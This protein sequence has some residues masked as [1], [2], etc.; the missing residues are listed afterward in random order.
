MD[1]EAT[2]RIVLLAKIDAFYKDRKDFIGED[3]QIIK[4]LR[5]HCGNWVSCN[6]RWLDTG[7]TC[8]FYK[9]LLKKLDQQPT[10]EDKTYV[11]A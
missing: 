9:V 6:F 4:V 10:I 2:Y 1:L 7:E 11:S 8:C 5:K 3:I